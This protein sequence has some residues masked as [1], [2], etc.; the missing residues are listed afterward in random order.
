MDGLLYAA[1]TQGWN[2]LSLSTAYGFQEEINFA[3]GAASG[4]I[5]WPTANLAMFFP[6][7]IYAPGYVQ[8]LFWVNGSAVAGNVQL[9]VYDESG[10]M[11]AQ[12][13]VTAAAG[14]TQP[15]AVS[16]PIP[17]AG[18]PGVLLTTGR[19]YLGVM[20]S[21]NTQKFVGWTTGA[22]ST[23][24]NRMLGVSEQAT[25]NPLPTSITFASSARSFV[26]IAGLYYA[27]LTI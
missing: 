14:T 1:D 24:I 4:D 26:P 15:Q 9:G 25:A 5:T 6:L 3:V 2:P 17:T 7:Y 18:P 23:N 8:Q 16:L 13:P 27:S 11:I 10:S 12:T 19:Y 20:A 21:T 22:A